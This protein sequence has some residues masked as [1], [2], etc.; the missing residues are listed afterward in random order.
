MALADSLTPYNERLPEHVAVGHPGRLFVCKLDGFGDDSEDV[1]AFVVRGVEAL[2]ARCWIR[3]SLKVL[4]FVMVFR[5]EFEG[6]GAD[7]HLEMW[8]ALCVYNDVLIDGFEHR[9]A[10]EKEWAGAL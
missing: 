10:V 8:R 6:D 2:E 3:C 1:E 5:D 4:D 9:R 7:M